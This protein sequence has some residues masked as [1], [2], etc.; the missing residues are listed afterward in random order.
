V[1]GFPGLSRRCGTFSVR[2]PPGHV[3]DVRTNP[4]EESMADHASSDARPCPACEASALAEA[5]VL[6]Q[7]RLVRC[8]RCGLVYTA[9]LPGL[10]ELRKIYN[11]VYEPGKLYKM[12]LDQLEQL[13][14]GEG[15]N[16]GFY[17]RK[18]FLNRFR[19]KPGDRLLEIG[20]GIGGFLV[21]AKHRGW[22]PEGVDIS[23]T[24]LNASATVHGI[25]VH[26]GTLEELDLPRGVYAAAVCWEVLEHLP[27]P[28]SFLRRV[29]ELLRPDGIFACS[30]P[31]AGRKAP[32]FCDTPG[33]A[34]LPP[35]HV[36]FWDCASFAACARANGFEP[37]YLKPKR[38]LF[39]MAG[40]R[41]HPF[42][43]ALNQAGALVGLREG[44]NIF[45]VL[46]PARAVGPSA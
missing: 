8:P 14:R 20:C 1:S 18:V 31:N 22:V 39:G 7:W 33:P 23:E 6:N 37:I 24:A 10:D 2:R 15:V 42:R 27:S 17:R 46:A 30:V 32:C 29:R 36:N 3:R 25:P 12:H 21:A 26:Q 44:P 9:R 13:K 5:G 43:W 11:D 35:I 38:L 16:Q 19:P 41:Q 4:V 40:A 45:A 28:S 34:S